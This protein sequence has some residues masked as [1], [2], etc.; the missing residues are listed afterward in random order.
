ML[1]VLLSMKKLSMELFVT[2]AT[3]DV[4][5]ELNNKAPMANSIIYALVDQ[6]TAE[7]T[8]KLETEFSKVQKQLA[9]LLPNPKNKSRG[10]GG[11]SKKNK[12]AMDKNKIPS[13]KRPPDP[14]AADAVKA[15]TKGRGKQPSKA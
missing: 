1:V 9:S 4:Q 8:K 12:L 13:Q 15:T 7:R 3:K 2:Q 6:N 11:A 10:P 14:K 5:M